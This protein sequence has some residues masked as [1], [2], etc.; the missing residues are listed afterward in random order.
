M[1]VKCPI[2]EKKIKINFNES[3]RVCGGKN[4]KC[5]NP[6]CGT[7]LWIPCESKKFALLPGILLIN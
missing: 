1:I 7:P 5:L 2:C 3:D 6:D 4:E